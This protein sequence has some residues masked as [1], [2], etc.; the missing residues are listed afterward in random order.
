MPSRREGE[1]SLSH[2]RWASSAEKCLWSRP[3]SCLFRPWLHPHIL[4]CFL[5]PLMFPFNHPGNINKNKAPQK[6]KAY[7]W[8]WDHQPSPAA[9]AEVTA[10]PLRHT[11]ATLCVKTS[12]P[13][14]C[15]INHWP[16][17]LRSKVHITL[18]DAG[19]TLEVSM[20]EGACHIHHPVICFQAHNPPNP[21]RAFQGHSSATWIQM[22][23]VP[24]APRPPSIQ[25][26]H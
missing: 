22:V 21:D 5:D 16:R 14:A 9:G 4:S 11:P 18:G 8:L 13:Q 19:R 24:R 15:L 7:S 20:R 6:S 3:H 26:N 25:E 12:K 10:W 2:L 23:R 17:I 1:P